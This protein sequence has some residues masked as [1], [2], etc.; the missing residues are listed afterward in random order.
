MAAHNF[1]AVAGGHFAD[2]TIDL[3]ETYPWY[4]N[5]YEV[6]L[7]GGSPPPM[8]A[9]PS[10]TLFGCPRPD[11]AG[12]L[13]S[14]TPSFENYAEET[15]FGCPP[16]SGK[17]PTWEEATNRLIYVALNMRRADTGS[18]P[19][20]GDVAIVFRH[21]VVSSMVEIAAIDT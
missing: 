1:P 8:A 20:F 14:D 9:R 12:V 6:A 3:L 21:K 16:F 11:L 17:T 4:L 13:G 7:V 15:I 2:M 5:Q 18:M 19:T 10:C